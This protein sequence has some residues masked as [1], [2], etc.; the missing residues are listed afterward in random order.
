LNRILN[1]N[2]HDNLGYGVRINTR[3]SGTLIAGDTDLHNNTLGDVLDQGQATHWDL[4]DDHLA[5][6][7]SVWDSTATSFNTVGTMGN[8]LNNAAAGGVDYTALAGAV[9]DATA[10]DYNDAGTMGEKVNT[11]SAIVDNDAIA[12]AVWAKPIEATFTAEQILRIAAAVL[13][14]KVSGAGTG[15]ETFTGIDGSTIRVVST[16]DTNGNR[17]NV[18][19]NGA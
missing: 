17:T 11:P 15:I 16:I 18:A 13:N 8:K 1:A 12:T 4:Q 14:G 10:T 9:W 2:I 6:A 7:A 3:G 19:N 5:I